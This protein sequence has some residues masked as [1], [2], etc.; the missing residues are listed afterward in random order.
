MVLR[1][2]GLL[3]IPTNVG[4]GVGVLFDNFKEAY[5][6]NGFDCN[7]GNNVKGNGSWYSAYN[8]ILIY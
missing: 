6:P 8:F 1:S 7:P 4:K 3:Y 5:P 2:I